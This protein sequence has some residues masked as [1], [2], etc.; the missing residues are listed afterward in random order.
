[1]LATRAFFC[2]GEV[3]SLIPLVN[4]D[5]FNSVL[6][7][8]LTMVNHPLNHH[9]GDYLF[10]FPKHRT[11]KS[12]LITWAFFQIAHVHGDSVSLHPKQ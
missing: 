2:F 11:S 1:M 7:L 10:T 3:L 6:L 4:L 5:L 9:L 12:K 8:F